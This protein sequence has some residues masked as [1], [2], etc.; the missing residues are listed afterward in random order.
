MSIRPSLQHP[1]DDTSGVMDQSV[2]V[3]MSRLCANKGPSQIKEF[4]EYLEF[5]KFK[6]MKLEMS[7][8]QNSLSKANAAADPRPIV[9]NKVLADL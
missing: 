6:E 4:Q 7:R 3:R 8:Q 5:K 1:A 2:S 9:P